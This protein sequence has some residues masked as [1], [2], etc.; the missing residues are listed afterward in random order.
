M[1]GTRDPDLFRQFVDTFLR[2]QLLVLVLVLTVTLQYNYGDNSQDQKAFPGN[3][4]SST[5]RGS[6]T[7]LI[8]ESPFWIGASILSSVCGQSHIFPIDLH[9]QVTHFSSSIIV[10]TILLSVGSQVMLLDIINSLTSKQSL[11][12]SWTE[13]Y[14]LI[15]CT[16]THQLWRSFK[17]KCQSVSV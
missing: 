17:C 7:A 10:E 11:M 9:Q 12:M 5:A 15:A 3:M 8:F 14:S 16:C 13:F 2:S 4:N 6:I 1:V